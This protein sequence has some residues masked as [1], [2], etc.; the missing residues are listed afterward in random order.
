MDVLHEYLTVN[1]ISTD[2]AKNVN[3]TVQWSAI[4]IENEYIIILYIFY[5]VNM[6]KQIL[7]YAS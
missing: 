7:R 6:V 1:E 3:E 5:D 4:F 2:T